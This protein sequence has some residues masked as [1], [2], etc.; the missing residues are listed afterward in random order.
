MVLL[1]KHEIETTFAK[2]CSQNK[3]NNVSIA[4]KWYQTTIDYLGLAKRGLMAHFPKI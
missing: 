2:I 1:D 3:S 4:E